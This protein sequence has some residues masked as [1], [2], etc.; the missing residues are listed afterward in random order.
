[1]NSS[2]YG[3]AKKGSVYIHCHVVNVMLVNLSKGFSSFW[4]VNAGGIC[5]YVRT[6]F[7]TSISVHWHLA[8]PGQT[9]RGLG[10]TLS[11]CEQDLST[12]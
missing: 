4:A 7:H 8:G 11:K 10:H 3:F 9:L 2:P 12:L 1:M 5:A 6:Y